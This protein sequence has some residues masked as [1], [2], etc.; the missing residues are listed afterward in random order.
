[1]FPTLAHGSIA[2]QREE[3]TRRAMADTFN[4]QNALLA[5]SA[6]ACFSAEVSPPRIM[7]SPSL[8][9]PMITTF[10]L[11][12]RANSFVASI[13]FHFNRFLLISSATIFE[14]CPLSPSPHWSELTF[15]ELAPK[16][17]PDASLKAT[18]PLEH[19]R[20]DRQPR[21]VRR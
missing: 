12:L 8:P 9:A 14:N 1:A 15:G 20:K 3:I 16:D 10:E 4:R 13:P 2:R 17:S 6:R 18:L 5:N 7:G 11:P 19:S 21:H